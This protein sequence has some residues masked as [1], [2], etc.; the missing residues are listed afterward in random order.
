MRSFTIITTAPNALMARIHD[1][2]PVIVPRAQYARWLDPAL[3][4]PAEI[5][6]MIASY[7]AGAPLA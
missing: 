4:D 6:T 3:R 2:M 5:Q 1:R 7:P